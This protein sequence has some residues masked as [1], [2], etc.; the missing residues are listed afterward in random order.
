MFQLDFFAVIA[1]FIANQQF[2]IFIFYL[3][4]P[5]GYFKKFF[6]NLLPVRSPSTW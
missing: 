3:F 2:K 5:V 4:F 1:F 6:I